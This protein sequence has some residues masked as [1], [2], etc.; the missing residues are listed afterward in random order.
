MQ[1]GC[2]GAVDAQEKDEYVED[3]LQI[4]VALG[5]L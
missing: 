1:S 2:C 3:V 5:V 4:V